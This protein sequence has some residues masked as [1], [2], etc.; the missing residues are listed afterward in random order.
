MVRITGF[1]LRV[2]VHMLG[3]LGQSWTVF[4]DAIIGR[5]AISLNFLMLLFP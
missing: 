4:W 3:L 5:R 2:S 1:A